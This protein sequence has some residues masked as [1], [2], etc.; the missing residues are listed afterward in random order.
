MDGDAATRNTQTATV[1][2]RHHVG[3]V[4]LRLGRYLGGL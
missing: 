2:A 3:I 4:R 1:V